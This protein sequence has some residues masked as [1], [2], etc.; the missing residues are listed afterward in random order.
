MREQNAAADV[1]R[2]RRNLATF[3]PGTFG[4]DMLY[5]FVAMFLTVYLTEVLQLTDAVLWWVAGIMLIARVVDAF[6]D[7]AMGSIVDST[8]T[9][10][11]QY[12]P[13]IVGGMI[14]S[15]AVTVLLFTDMGARDGRY[16]AYFAI[17]YVLWGLAWTT[18]DIPYWSLLPALSQDQH[19]RE[20][21]GSVA[22]LF[23]TLGLFTVVVAVIPVTSALARTL[24]SETAAW[25][26]FAI[27]MVALMVAFQLITVFGV[28]EPRDAMVLSQRTSLRDMWRALAGNDQLL[29][30]SFAMLL[31][32]TGFQITTSFGVYF[33]KYAYRDE[34]MYSVFAAVLGVAQLVGYVTFSF[35]AKRVSRRRIYL[36]ATVVILAGYGVFWLAPMNMIPIG[37]AGLMLFTAQAYVVML[38]LVYLSDTVEYGQWKLGRR[39]GAVTFALQPFI[40]KV[41]GALSMAIVSA[42]LIISGINEAKSPERLRPG[43]VETMKLVMMGLPVI[44]VAAAYLIMRAKFRIDEKLYAEIIADLRAR[45]QQH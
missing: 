34:N 29:W 43:G 40:N 32:M 1:R 11:G 13:W 16:I 24:G 44:L 45:E 38:I 26:A 12:K 20:Q 30:V 7:I 41:S 17:V 5:T 10:W 19:R 36:V 33:F 2:D 39:N 8:H 23:G 37:I 31:F 25:Q 14:A 4:R 42:T 28:R 9:R 3:G 27:A 22:K 21:I 6:L 18:N 35:V 15:A